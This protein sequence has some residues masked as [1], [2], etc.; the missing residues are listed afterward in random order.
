MM[1][2]ECLDL[3]YDDIK[4]A[5]DDH[6]KELNDVLDAIEAIKESIEAGEIC[7]CCMED[8]CDRV[9]MLLIDAVRKALGERKL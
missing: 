9:D 8:E 4:K 2:C 1:V 7:G 3:E 6:P 5:I